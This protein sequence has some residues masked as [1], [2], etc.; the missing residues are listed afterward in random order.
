M[1]MKL[2][3]SFIHKSNSW[4]SVVMNNSVLHIGQIVQPFRHRADR[5]A[6]QAD[7]EA[8]LRHQSY[9]HSMV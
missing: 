2:L 3:L 9:P 7:S 6:N 4:S 5:A 1:T 8:L